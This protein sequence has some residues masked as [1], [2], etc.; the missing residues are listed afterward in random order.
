MPTGEIERK[1]GIWEEQKSKLYAAARKML[2]TA[3]D[4]ELVQNKA[5]FVTVLQAFCDSTR[6]LN[7]DVTSKVL[8]AR[9]R[10]VSG[11]QTKAGLN[12]AA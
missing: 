12:A 10:I 9:G 5:E 2:A 6:V 8:L 4:R 3:D 11:E 1:S 7:E